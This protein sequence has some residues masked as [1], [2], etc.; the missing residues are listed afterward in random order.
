MSRRRPDSRSSKELSDEQHQLL[1]TDLVPWVVKAEELIVAFEIVVARDE[2]TPRHFPRL[3]GVAYMLA[4]FATEVLLKAV[5]VRNGK[6]GIDASGKFVLRSHDL[7]ELAQQCDLNISDEHSRLLE[8]LREYVEW[9]GRY[10]APMKS[11]VMQP[12]PLTNGGFAPVTAHW[13]GEDWAAIRAFMAELRSILPA[14]R[15]PEI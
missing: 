12:R 3:S 14:V 1:L 6:G 15:N 13:A 7:I 2:L 9:A 4:G 10:P 11:E 5:L 8:R